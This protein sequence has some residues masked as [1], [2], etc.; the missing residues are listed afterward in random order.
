MDPQ[1]FI[2]YNCHYH[3]TGAIIGRTIR[4]AHRPVSSIGLAIYRS[5]YSSTDITVT[6]SFD[7]TRDSCWDNCWDNPTGQLLGQPPGQPSE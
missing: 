2:E 6:T 7:I 1:L 3:P 4:F 5:D